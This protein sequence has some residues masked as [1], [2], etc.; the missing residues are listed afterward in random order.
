MDEGWTKVGDFLAQKCEVLTLWASAGL[1]PLRGRSRL[2]KV[3]LGGVQRQAGPSGT[4][5]SGPLRTCQSDSDAGW[6]GVWPKF[7]QGVW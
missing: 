2:S 7:G 6:T 1:T 5:G 4:K 3:Y